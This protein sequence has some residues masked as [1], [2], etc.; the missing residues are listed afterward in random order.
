MLIEQKNYNHIPTYV[1]KADAA[2]EAASAAAA[3]SAG[4]NNGGNGG[5][6]PTLLTTKK[7]SAERDKVQSK[8]DLATALS[9][10]GQLSYEKA[11]YAFLRIGSVQQLGDWVGK[12]SPIFFY[13]DLNNESR[14]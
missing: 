1:F 7:S 8:L 9:Y 6:A 11:A 3:A 2:L 14:S 10:L 13:I 4:G 12:V 5:S